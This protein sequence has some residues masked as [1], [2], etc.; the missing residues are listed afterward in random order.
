MQKQGVHQSEWDWVGS[1][2]DYTIENNGTVDDLNLEVD[3][4]IRQLRDPQ[5]SSEVA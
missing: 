2:F 1:D 3:S 5:R 4:I